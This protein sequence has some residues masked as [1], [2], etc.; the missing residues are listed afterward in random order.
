MPTF[1][2]EA[3]TGAG[4]RVR[5]EIEA[6]DSRIAIERLQDGGLIPIEAKPVAARAAGGGT[7]RPGRAGAG[8]AQLT[9]A[10]RELATLV[11]AGQTIE[12]ALDMVAED[13][14]SKKLGAALQRVLA[15]VRGGSS[16][17]DALAAEP[18]IFPPVYVAMV[19]A[20]EASGQLERTLGELVAMREKSEAMQ[21]KLTSAMIYPLL[22]VCTAIGA[23]SILLTV[24]VPQFRPLFEQ[25]GEQLPA[26]SRVV[27]D[28]A[29]FVQGNGVLILSVLLV[30]LL[31]V[32]R[33][34]A[35][36]G[37]GRAFDRFVLGMPL[38]GRLARERITAQFCRGLGS[39]LSGGLDLPTALSMTRQ[40]LTNR[41]AQER[42]DALIDGVRQGR[43]LSDCL[44][45]ADIL[46]PMAAK[47]LRAGEESGRLRPVAAYLADAFDERVATRLTRLV[48]IL[49][50]ALVVVLGILV[51]GIVMSI[52]TAVISIND[53]AL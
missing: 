2:Y 40:M 20:G 44:R 31:V 51:G 38:L 1:T 17:A 49:E 4:E 5:G 28:L 12:G 18:R 23:L 8:P 32:P 43:T 33:I 19:R 11:G 42:L 22:L 41:W 35:R 25:A 36:E 47:L 10:T 27:L 30:L 52:L 29:T 39:L 6:S 14:G 9:A 24:V 3:L 16:L 7:V 45:E 48:A 34:L 53:L 15:Q 37:P 26:M 46:V 50:P 21:A 13:T